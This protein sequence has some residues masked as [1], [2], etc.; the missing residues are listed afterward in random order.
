MASKK[1]SNDLLEKLVPVLLVLSIAL[2]FAVGMLWQKVS[3]LESGS[4]KVTDT[5][6]DN[7][8]ET[9]P[10]A[11]PSG[12]LSDDQAE[13]LVSSLDL[14]INKG[15]GGNTV[16]F[17]ENDHIRGSKDAQVL[18]IEY[19]D[20]ECPFCKRF[21]ETAQRAVDEYDG[22]VAWV[23]RHFPL[24]LL[25]S[26]ARTEAQ[27]AECA[28]E[29]GGEE[30][31]WKYVD[32]IFEVTPS[33]NGLNLD[34]LPKLATDVGLNGVSL[35]ACV[36]NEKYKDRVES[37]YQS[38]VEAGVSGT[39]GNFIVNTNGEVWSVPGAVPYESLK[40]TI[41]EALQN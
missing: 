39:P 36:D 27:A 31:F 20:L 14:T 30:G 18:L 17:R 24:D 3:N 12:K 23:Y 28:Y 9:V 38:G 29:L 40:V 34:D 19:S 7:Q 21:H 4:T 13:Q 35:K 33:N 22:K 2:A 37:D 6:G 1:T 16:S 41:E 8:E 25:H 5:T 26:K 32:R 11:P 10:Q 15:V